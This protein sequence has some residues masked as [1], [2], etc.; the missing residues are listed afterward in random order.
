MEVGLVKVTTSSRART[1][2]GNCPLT[3]ETGTLTSIHSTTIAPT[4]QASD[5]IFAADLLRHIRQRCSP[6]SARWGPCPAAR[7]C[8]AV[9]VPR[10]RSWGAALLDIYNGLRER[11]DKVPTVVLAQPRA[12]LKDMLP[13]R[14]E[15][16]LPQIRGEILHNIVRF[17][18]PVPIAVLDVV[19]HN[20]AHGLT[21]HRRG[22]NLA[23]GC[24]GQ[25]DER[26]LGV[27]KIGNGVI[28]ELCLL[29]LHQL[30]AGWREIH[31]INPN[32]A[33]GPGP[34]RD[35]VNMHMRR[36]CLPHPVIQRFHQVL[37]DMQLLSHAGWDI[38]FADPMAFL[39]F[40]AVDERRLSFRRDDHKQQTVL[41]QD[42]VDGNWPVT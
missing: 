39:P 19:L 14:S 10:I 20:A 8:P 4:R 30:D 7:T 25:S 1:V 6:F 12:H 26:D 13:M 41:L 28:A 18:T 15:K 16:P 29:V 36:R 17:D 21:P 9:G 33:N 5:N 11:C 24:L 35:A 23:A 31:L 37:R 38:D 42:V 2:A 22:Y 40:Q 3:S 34:S 27:I 32:R